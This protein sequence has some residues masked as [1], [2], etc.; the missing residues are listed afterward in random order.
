MI[1]AV[2]IDART[3]SE[4]WDQFEE[5]M[6]NADGLC[7]IDCETMDRNRHAGL[8]AFNNK[9]RHV[10][11]HR[12]T[13]MTGM[14]FYPKGAKYAYY[15]NLAQADV[16]NRLPPEVVPRILALKPPGVRWVA[17]N[18]SFE[19]VMFMQCHGQDLDP[20]LCSMQL[21]VSSHGP[22]EFDL[23][24]F[25]A[26]K[27][28]IKPI[29]QDILEHFGSYDKEKDKSGRNLTPD[30]AFV[31]GQFT[32]KETDAAFSYN[33]FVK[34]ISFGYSLKRLTKSLFNVDQTTY[35]DLLKAHGAEDM[36][37]LTGDQVVAYGAD[38][39]YWAVRVFD[40]LTSRML[41]NNP[42]ALTA[43]FETE[44]SMVR[45]YAEVWRQGLRIN[46]EEIARR[47][48]EERDNYAETLR[49]FKRALAELLPFDRELH[50][51]LLKWQTKWYTEEKAPVLRQRLIDWIDSP[52]TS[53]S[54]E[55]CFQ[56]SNPIGNA[57]AEEKGIK[58][59]K[60]GKLNLTHYYQMRL[61]L[62][63][64]LGHKLVRIG[65]EIT[66]DKDARARMAETYSNDP[67]KLEVLKLINRISQIEQAMKLYLTPYSQLTDPETG[68]MYAV[69]T[70]MLASR[71]MATKYPNPMQLA[72]RGESVYVRGF[73][74]G[75]TDDHVIVSAD[76]SSVELVEI[77]EFSGDP[78]FARCFGQDPYEDLHTGAMVDCLKAD[79]RYTWLTEEEVLE[80]FKRNLNPMK[81][82]LFD[83][84]GK[85]LEPAKWVKVMRTEVGK[86]ANFN[87]WYSGALGTVAEK[88]GWD[89]ATHWAAVDRYR[90][91]FSVAEQWRLNLIAEGCRNGFITLPDGHRR[92]RLEATDAWYQHM[93]K[94]FA[95]ILADPKVLAFGDLALRRIQTRA[96]NQLVNSMIQG[97]CATLAKRSILKM[98]QTMDRDGA[99][100]MLPIHDE[101]LYSV[102]RD[103]VPEFIPILRDAMCN[104]PTIIK[105]LKLQCNVA[106]GRTFAPYDPV[107][108]KLTQIE[109]DEAP[110]IE[111]VIGKEFEG[112]K[113]P[114]EM[115]PKVVEWM[116]AA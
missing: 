110:V 28:P 82:E 13:V 76:W 23:Q 116:M 33:G 99:R 94:K 85:P 57:W 12:R 58:L 71:R 29:L 21:A 51:G 10:F 27:L 80:Q 111:G 19:L 83:L 103:Y 72:K 105:N 92:V 95:E 67:R 15:V 101:L 25:Y 65:G 1:E 5:D 6:R 114:P 75:D 69:L 97:S 32:G 8:Q 4:V 115:Y 113:L 53:D 52:D 41:R 90:Q 30:Q 64:L 88:L 78:E 91:R 56:V 16:E 66:T 46:H 47:R 40:E 3:T 70:S 59:P 18:A 96:K 35:E 48:N 89:D 108:P 9:T 62:H 11:D 74:L 68:C 24:Q 87:Y 79:P 31:L 100:F 42:T 20:I 109:F 17:H 63:D 44:N 81:R 45:V 104:H 55:Q 77:G 86:G 61:I 98:E 112:K 84:A 39:A 54:F 36:A 73:Y 34:S 50:E 37:D 2:L 106:V 26:T 38:D 7:G 22:D 49:S 107:R 102:H 93:M 43:Y 60:S 14:S